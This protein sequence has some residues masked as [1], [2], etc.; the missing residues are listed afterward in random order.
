MFGTYFLWIQGGTCNFV[1][2]GKEVEKQEHGPAIQ[3]T[4]LAVA[5]GAEDDS[6]HQIKESHWLRGRFRIYYKNQE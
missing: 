3:K 6:S 4:I 5:P 1:F 2:T